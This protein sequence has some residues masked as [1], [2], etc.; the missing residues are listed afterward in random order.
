M[1]ENKTLDCNL[2]PFY[3]LKVSMQIYLSNPFV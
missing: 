1:E 2:F 3:K